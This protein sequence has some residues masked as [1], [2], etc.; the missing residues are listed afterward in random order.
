MSIVRVFFAILV[1]LV[2][3][4]VLLAALAGGIGVWVVKKPFTAGATRYFERANEMLG[5][6]EQA[7]SRVNSI[8]AKAVESVK[9][10]KDRHAKLSGENPEKRAA[11]DLLAR[12]INR[13][14]APRVEEARGRLEAI[15][16]IAAALQSVT[17]DLK[18]SPLGLIRPPDPDDLKRVSSQLSKVGTTSQELRDMLRDPKNGEGP[19]GG[20]RSKMIDVEK[21]LESI[22]ELTAEY[23][24]KV[25]K[26]RDKLDNLHSEMEAWIT[27]AALIVSAVL[28]WIAISQISLLIH[29]CSWLRGRRVAGPQGA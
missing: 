10:I 13:E 2:S 21:L 5:V 22:Q 16:E 1:I 28:F 8:L 18:D 20:V 15:T 4:A 7:L 6:A 19:A 23:Q 12:R 9:A 11:M 25:T 29:A 26:L 24:A 17:S 3:V 27:P 14:V